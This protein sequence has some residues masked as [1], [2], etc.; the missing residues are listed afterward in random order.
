M[1]K[2]GDIITALPVPDDVA[3]VRDC[4]GDVLKF[5]R[6]AGH[7]HSVGYGRCREDGCAGIAVGDF[8]PLTVLKVHK[9]KPSGPLVLTLPE[10]PAGA[11][12]LIAN[13][14]DGDGEVRYHRQGGGWM[15]DG[16]SGEAESLVDILLDEDLTGSVTV[17]FAPPCEPRIWPKLDGHEFDSLPDAVTVDDDD[18]RGVWRRC[19]PKGVLYSDGMTGMTLADLRELGD[20]REVLGDA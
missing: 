20:V 18:H 14:M 7:W 6:R 17:E 19:S 10:A 16:W 8:L 4:T 15:R 3:K 12:A 11:V 9:P 2:I 5:Q 1:T 13:E